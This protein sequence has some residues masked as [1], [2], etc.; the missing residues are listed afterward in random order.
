MPL[1][2]RMRRWVDLEET[3][4]AVAS[5]EPKVSSRRPRPDLATAY[6]EPRDEHERRVAEL[7][8]TLLGVRPVGVNDDFFAL[9]GHSLF[10]ARAL[11]R[12]RSSFGVSLP[13][14]AFFET[15]TAAGLALRIAAAEATREAGYR[16]DAAA[17]EARVEIEL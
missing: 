14:G 13:L 8:E 4:A 1:Q 15:P 6:V 17:S 5:P 10:A 12:I 3:P 11:S 2:S 9:G 7:L 16:T